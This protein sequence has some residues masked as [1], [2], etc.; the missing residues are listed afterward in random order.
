M[1]D[2]AR[3]GNSAPGFKKK[4]DYII[5]LAPAG[6]NLRI[7]FEGRTVVDSDD[8]LLMREQNHQPVFYFPRKDVDMTLFRRTDHSTH[9]PFKG[10]A[11]YWTLEAED[12]SEE[13]VMWSYETPFDEVAGIADYVAFYTD[14]IGSWFEN[15]EPLLGSAH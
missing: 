7:E 3:S 5:E 4:P 2:T 8:A 9:C 12:S 6:R 14:R 15:G 1:P 11:S 10:D 13:N